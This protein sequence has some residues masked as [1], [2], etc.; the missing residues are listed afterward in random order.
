[1]FL[2]ATPDDKLL[3]IF[4]DIENRYMINENMRIKFVSK[5]GVK[6]KNIVQKRN[7]F[8]TNCN[9]D[10]CIPSKNAK[11]I[12]KTSNCK[13]MNVCYTAECKN[14]K[15]V[16]KRR[17][18]I[19]ETARNIH[20]RSAEHYK[21]CDNSNKR[22]WMRKHIEKEHENNPDNCEFEWNVIGKFQKPMLRQ[23]TE[24]IHINNTNDNE[25]LN[26]KNEYFQNSIKN[27]ELTETKN[28]IVCRLCGRKC[29]EYASLQEHFHAV[30]ERLKCEQ[31]D[32]VSFGNRDLKYH[33]TSNHCQKNYKREQCNEHFAMEF[34]L[35]NHIKI[36][37]D[38]QI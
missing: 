17:V 9:D 10:K 33:K 20:A 5:S 13:K 25:L 30:H 26:M 14:C 24:A 8:E 38:T 12:D 16:G 18:Y 19:G 23:L 28:N 32:Y 34:E 22:N 36:I 29:E 21:D 6:L 7:P 15:Y 2:D 3:K 37:H 1:M 35:K 4:R 27:L 31:C 11:L